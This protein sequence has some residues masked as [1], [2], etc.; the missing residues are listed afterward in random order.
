[1]LRRFAL[2]AVLATACTNIVWAQSGPLTLKGAIAAAM[3]ASPALRVTDDGRTLAEI[4]ERQASAR[5][6]FKL[7]PQFQSGTDPSGFDQR[8][9]G[10]TVSKR[11][12]LGTSLQLGVN[13]YRFGNG[14][15][16]LRDNGY[17][18]SL[19]QPLTRGFGVVASA[20]RTNAERGVVSAGRAHIEAR[21][22]LVVSV[23]EAYFSVIRARRLV[24]AA[25]RALDRAG[26]LRMQSEAR[27]K[28]GLATELDVLRADLLA[29]QSETALVGQQ[30]S[31]ETALDALKLLLGRRPEDELRVADEGVDART[32]DAL[33][34]DVLGT[35]GTLDL[36]IETAVKTA[37][38]TRHEVRE[39]RDRIGDA[40]LAETVARWHLLPPVTLDVSYTRRGIGAASPVFGELF[41]GWR[42]GVSTTYA[43][44][45]SDE[46]AAAATAA[47]SVRAAEQASMDTERRVSEEVRRAH[48]AWTRTAST[49]GIQSK[50]VDLAERQLRLAQIRYERGVAGNFDVVD[51]EANLFEAQSAMI[52][53]QVERALSWLTLTRLTGTLDPERLGR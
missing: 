15:T 27:S 40:R 43:L 36:P 45:H 53:A 5:F 12:P 39:A 30:E 19:S 16:E 26:R 44:D 2:T 29:S 52:G 23:A 31:L 41:N 21:Q 46:S 20:D 7:M 38:T 9:L 24:D 11:L 51:A 6:G 28:V 1:M 42:V 10:L 33:V 34:L 8:T 37:L 25:Q 35:T 49:L 17:S 47:V 3:A 4:R 48:R 32:P 18:I 14:A 22:Q 50:A 13:S